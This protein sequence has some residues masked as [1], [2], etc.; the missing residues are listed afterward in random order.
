MN[1]LPKHRDRSTLAVFASCLALL[2]CGSQSSNEPRT[3]A[4]SPAPTPVPEPTP[5]AGAPP[6][7]GTPPGDG[8]PPGPGMPPAPVVP[9]SPPEPPG[10]GGMP[11]ASGPPSGRWTHSRTI[12]LDTTP[13]GANVMED[14]ARYPLAVQLDKS[15]FDFDQA[16]PGGADVR[17]FDSAGKALPH[18]IE[19]WDREGGKAAIWVLLDVV[20]GNSNDQSIVMKWGNPTAPDISDSRAVFKKENGFVGVWHLDEDG[21]TVAGGYKDASDQEAHG[22][23]VGMIPGSRVDARVGKGVHLD[24]PTGQNTARWIRVDGEKAAQFNPGPPITVSIWVLGY[25]YPIYSYETMISKGDTSWTLQK[26]RY[27]SGQGYQSCVRTPGYHLCAYNFSRQALVTRQW[28]HFMLVLEE[29]SMKLYINGQLNASTSAG[30]WNKGPHPLGIGNQTQALGGRRQW[31][32]ILDEARVMQAA[33]SP[34]WAKLEY[35]SQKESPTLLK[36]GEPRTE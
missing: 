31:D 17:F 24:N 6:S 29:P 28:L 21:N 5:G 12:T 4:P 34:A 33:R 1:V 36:F 14:V 7:A 23:G 22:T 26:V 32:G 35:E 13:A 25:S 16:Q 20:E 2:A 10:A 11:G 18:A 15:R 9:P 30:P 27:S 8:T 19:L 3:A